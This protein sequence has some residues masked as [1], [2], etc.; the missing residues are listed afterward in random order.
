MTINEQIRDTAKRR[1]KLFSKARKLGY[2]MQKCKWS[3]PEI[4]GTVIYFQHNDYEETCISDDIESLEAFIR[5]A[6][7]NYKLET[8]GL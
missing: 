2:S 5:T 1:A 7:R 8:L 4:V 3:T 6:E